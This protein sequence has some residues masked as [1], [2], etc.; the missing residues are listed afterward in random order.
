MAAFIA[1]RCRAE[2]STRVR[3]DAD[4]NTERTNERDDP[5]RI[6]FLFAC[7]FLSSSSFPRLKSG[8]AGTLLKGRK[9]FLAERQ[10]NRRLFF[11]FAR[12]QISPRL[13]VFFRR[14]EIIFVVGRLWTGTQCPTDRRRYRCRCGY[15]TSPLHGGIEKIAVARRERERERE[16]ERKNI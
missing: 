3:I 8:N 10:K 7:T 5:R 14:G 6:L 1:R 9:K 12:F 2:R 11:L 15:R 13:F 4:S 16:K